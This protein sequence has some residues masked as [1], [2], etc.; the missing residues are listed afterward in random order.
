MEGCTVKK[1]NRPV[2]SGVRRSAWLAGLA[3]ALILRL[4]VSTQADELMA[5]LDG[6]RSASE[7][8]TPVVVLYQEPPSE[9]DELEGPAEEPPPELLELEQLL[10]EPVLVAEPVATTISRVEERVSESPGTVYVFSRDIIFKRGYRSLG[11]LL[12]TVPGFTVFHRDLQFVV[13]VRGFLANDNDKV[14]LLIN[15]QR[16]LGMHEQEF[17][18][19]P[20][21]L[22]NVDRVEVV[23]GP[24]SLF[25]QANTLAATINVITR[26]I[27]GVEVIG[28]TG[29]ALGYSG[30]VMAGRRCGDDNYLTFSFTTEDKRGFDAWQPDFRAGL[31]GTE[32][33][34]ELIQPNYFSVLRWQNGGLAVQAIAYRSVLPELL[35]NNNPANGGV[36]R[37]EYYS[38]FVDYEREFSCNLTGIAKYRLDYKEQARQNRDDAPAPFATQRTNHGELGLRYA[39]ID[40]HLIQ[41]GVQAEHDDNFGAF[42]TTTLVDRDSYAVGFYFDD[43]IEVSDRL[44]LIAGVRVDQNTRLPDSNDWYPGA[45]AAVVYDTTDNWITKVTYNRSVRMPSALTA[46]NRVWGSNN[47]PGPDNPAWASIS[48]TANVPEILSTIELHNVFYIGKEIRIGTIYYHE[49]LADFITW[50]GPWSNGGNFRGDGIELTLD[51]EV[52]PCL[53][54]WANCAYNDTR[55][56]LFNDALFG[57]G[58]PG[59]A[60]HHAYINPAGRIIG[61]PEWTAN[62]G[63]DW[64]ITDSLTFSPAVRYFTE[65]AAVE[66]DTP[67]TNRFVKVRNQFYFDAAL[68]WYNV[69]CR[70]MDLRLSGRNL[71]HNRAPI[72]GQLVGDLYRPRG[73]ELVL[74]LD[75]RF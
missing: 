43:Q 12:R 40:R 2:S 65:Q 16:V 44:K 51:A 52:N 39:G 41:S 46:L 64:D 9:P 21:N 23:V 70:D 48:P 58:D 54:M 27:D 61:S 33:T 10:Q 66:Q 57:P 73:Y 75:M 7:P 53:D 56:N 72:G 34:G 22:D 60:E 13:G 25:Q 6:I 4:S 15:G 37:E 59:E 24:S 1:Q 11:E 31:A 26:S 38:L 49:E 67:T 14:S 8:V 63:L 29:N 30:T 18:N 68:T 62:L 74:T 71:L 35:I 45:R 50:F 69:W 17:L 3:A 42:G 47:P 32:M 19:G 36:F 5:P 28:A 20:I 55:L